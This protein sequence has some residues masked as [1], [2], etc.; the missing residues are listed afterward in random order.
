VP[1]PKHDPPGNAA[2]QRRIA[3][4]ISDDPALVQVFPRP[5][6]YPPQAGRE[7]GVDVELAIDIVRLA[8]DDAYDV[9]VLVSADTDLTPPLEFV[10]ERYPDMILETV[11]FRAVAGCEAITAAPIDIR[12]GGVIRR[13]V[14]KRDFDRVVDRR[15]FMQQT[16]PPAQLIGKDRWAGIVRRLAS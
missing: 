14:D 11:A 10:H 4:W 8:I 13:R 6:R 5:L 15:N 1:T 7:K 2:T 9:A 16:K 12:G 3:A